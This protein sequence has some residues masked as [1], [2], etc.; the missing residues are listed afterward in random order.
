MKK[1]FAVLTLLFAFA[2]NAN[3]QQDKKMN[4]DDAA[5]LDAVK[6]TEYVG[7]QGTQQDD[8]IRL[9][10]MKHRVM[11]DATISDERKKEMSRQVGEKIKASLTSEQ[12]QKLEANPELMAKLTGSDAATATPAPA[13]K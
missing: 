2:I 7:L 11:D 4:P 3:A 13:K 1:L 10:V 9:F 8:F 5:K 12:I 6:L